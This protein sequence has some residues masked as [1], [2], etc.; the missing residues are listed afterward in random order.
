M[1]FLV[2][3]EINL[4]VDM[5]GDKRDLL[6]GEEGRRARELAELGHLVRLWRIPG[7]RANVG[8]WQAEDATELHGALS[9]LPFFPWMDIHVRPLAA[10]PSD[11]AKR[12][13]D[14]AKRS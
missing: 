12:Q 14:P 3:I 10:H 9:S 5:P 2:E 13:S 1:E 7:R 6:V 11:P 8:L 4:P